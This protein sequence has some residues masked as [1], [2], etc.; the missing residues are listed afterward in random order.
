VT[1]I[2]KSEA[3]KQAVEAFYRA[4]LQRWPVPHREAVVP[5]CQGDTFVVVSGSEQAPPVVLFHG[6][7]ANSAVWIRDVAEWARS[8]RVYAVD[9]IGEPA[10]LVR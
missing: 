1:G 8:H 4:A 2:Y 7:G 6:S 3:G 5:T 9:M 10:C